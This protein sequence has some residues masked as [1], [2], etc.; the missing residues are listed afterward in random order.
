VTFQCQ[1]ATVR[2]YL[3]PQEYQTLPEVPIKK[4]KKKKKKKHLPIPMHQSNILSREMTLWWHVG[5]LRQ[6]G[7]H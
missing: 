7:N 3:D 4:K 6:Y 1:V 5:N 2:K